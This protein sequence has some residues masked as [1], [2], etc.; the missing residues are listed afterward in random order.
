MDERFFG[1][2]YRVVR[3]VPRG[4]VATY[5]QIAQ[6]LG[7]PRAAR[8]V[9]WALRAL[10]DGSGV[11]WQ[12]VVNA[13]GTISLAQGAGGAEIQRLLLEEEGIAFD[14]AGRIDLARFGWAGPDVA[15]QAALLGRDGGPGSPL[16]CG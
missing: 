4:R 11:P 2:V 6:A 1:R 8:T 16:G 15:E 10:P 5:G 3:L 9:G 13:R 14:D 7:A 12:R